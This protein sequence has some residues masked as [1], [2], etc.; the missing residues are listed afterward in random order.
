[1]T[2]CNLDRRSFD[3]NFEAGILVYDSNFASTL[4]FLQ[5]SYM[6]SSVL[7]DPDDW[8]RRPTRSRLIEN[9]AGLLSPL[10]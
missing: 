6:D 2:S 4:R 5:Q 10:L 8:N 9:A 1:M 3:L 7:V